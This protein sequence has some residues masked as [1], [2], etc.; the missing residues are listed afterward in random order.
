[1]KTSQLNIHGN[2]T[3]RLFHILF[4]V[5]D[6]ELG[7]FFFEAVKVYD[8]LTTTSSYLLLGV[9]GDTVYLDDDVDDGE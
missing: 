5:Q 9:S 1:M 7:L 2:R 8:R 6:A 3:E 4:D